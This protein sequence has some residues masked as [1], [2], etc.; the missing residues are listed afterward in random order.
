M[1]DRMD[2]DRASYDLW[3]VDLERGVET[4]L[5]NDPGT[6]TAPYF[7][8]DGRMLYSRATVGAPRLVEK[9]AQGEPRQLLPGVRFQ[10]AVG[11]QPPNDLVY[12]EREGSAGFVVFRVSLDR[13]EEPERV[14]DGGVSSATLA[15]DGSLLGFVRRESTRPEA[16]LRL[17]DGGEVVRASVAGAA[18]ARFEPDGSALLFVGLDRQ[19]WRAPI[20]REPT[21]A[22]G[23]PT[24]LFALPELGWYG[25]H[26]APDASI[27]ALAHTVD[28][29][30]APLKLMVH[31]AVP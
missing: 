11:M 27:Y 4:R 31:A 29:A 25:F 17:V 2:L 15:R 7:L 30:A 10:T 18:L 16:Y 3:T 14:L 19:L 24:L 21:L 1:I 8:P 28:S 12:L 26:V 20:Y 22:V 13:P 23:E 6:E 9:V 5:T